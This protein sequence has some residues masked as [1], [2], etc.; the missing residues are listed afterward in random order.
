MVTFT[1]AWC[2]WS[3]K[4]AIHVVFCLL[5]S[6]GIEVSMKQDIAMCSCDLYAIMTSCRAS[7]FGMRGVT[8][9]SYCF[10][11]PLR[12]SSSHGNISHPL[13][14]FILHVLL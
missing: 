12:C 6:V 1:T 4:T 7:L 2:D 11:P 9:L 3:L 10:A 5:T 13:V 8:W 14:R